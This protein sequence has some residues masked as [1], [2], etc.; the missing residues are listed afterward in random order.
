MCLSKPHKHQSS[1]KRAEERLIDGTFLLYSLPVCLP[2]VGCHRAAFRAWTC[3]LHI[4]SGSAHVSRIH[5]I[6][7]EQY[8]EESVKYGLETRTRLEEV[9][10]QILLQNKHIYACMATRSFIHQIELHESTSTLMLK[11]QP[12]VI[13]HITQERNFRSEIQLVKSYYITG[14]FR[15]KLF[16]SNLG[17]NQSKA[18]NMMSA[19]DQ[20]VQRSSTKSYK[21]R[22]KR[23]IWDGLRSKH[24]FPFIKT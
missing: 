20:Q 12:C 14:S 16:R 3:W 8:S 17:R 6:Q 19:L 22:W 21:T 10:I 18:T 23:F 15:L 13:T 1:S 24:S 4:Q 7:P 9:W 5:S 11:T 2:V